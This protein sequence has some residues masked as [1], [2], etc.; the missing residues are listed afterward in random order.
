MGI[1][2]DMDAFQTAFS[3]LRQGLHRPHSRTVAFIM[4]S[5]STRV[6][7]TMKDCAIELWQCQSYFIS[8]LFAQ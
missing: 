7:A 4:E 3:H 2:T 5:F 1:Y 8:F 6:S